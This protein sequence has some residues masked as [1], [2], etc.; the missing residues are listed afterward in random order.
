LARRRLFGWYGRFT[1]GLLRCRYVVI[2]MLV[3]R[4]FGRQQC[5]PQGSRG[6][7]PTTTGPPG[8]RKDLSGGTRVRWYGSQTPEERHS[9]WDPETSLAPYLAVRRTENAR[10]GHP[11][12]WI[13]M[14]TKH[15]TREETAG[16]KR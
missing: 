12:L 15:L 8:S 5:S 3:A 7:D 6:D 9:E 13:L 1:H 16:G 2:D 4:A 11:Q 10:T 14:W